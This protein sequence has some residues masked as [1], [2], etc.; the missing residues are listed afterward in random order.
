[1]VRKS[2]AGEQRCRAKKADAKKAKAKSESS[3]RTTRGASKST[4]DPKAPKA[5]KTPKPVIIPS[6][7]KSTKA[8]SMEFLQGELAK[9]NEA[10][11]KLDANDLKIEKL[12][13]KLEGVNKKVAHNSKTLALIMP[14][15]FE[16]GT[17]RTATR[18][19]TPKPSARAKAPKTPKGTNKYNLEDL[20]G[21]LAEAIEIGKDIKALG[22][23][24]KGLS[25]D[26]RDVSKKVAHN[27]KIPTGVTPS[28]SEH[29]A[30]LEKHGGR[31]ARLEYCFFAICAYWVFSKILETYSA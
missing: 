17:Q 30:V 20:Q 5:A 14:S 13:G 18:A 21:T 26:L 10:G 22:G 25:H 19:T 11:K 3:S 27:S 12:S 28:Y 15:H 6:S 8:T 31:I 1:M 16:H 23:E 7:P 4:K 29:G 9:A 24:V 2:R